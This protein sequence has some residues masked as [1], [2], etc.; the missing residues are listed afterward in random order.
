MANTRREENLDEGNNN[1]LEG[2]VEIL[3]RIY[4]DKDQ[5]GASPSLDESL[6]CNS[7]FVNQ[8]FFIRDSGKSRA[9]LWAFAA[10]MAVEFGKETTN[11]ACIEGD[12]SPRSH[13]AGNQE[14]D[15]IFTGST[16]LVF[17]F[18]ILVS[19]LVRSR[20][21]VRSSSRQGVPTALRFLIIFTFLV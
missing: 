2:T 6:R 5:P 15:K 21:R 9:D 8:H 1:G 4:T 3:E 14:V 7:Q 12:S 13:S 20:C 16:A 18:I 19:L 11:I 10:L 17:V